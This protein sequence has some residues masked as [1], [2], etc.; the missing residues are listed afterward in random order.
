MQL[1]S[2]FRTS[3]HA[4]AGDVA[5]TVGAR[6]DELGRR[7]LVRFDYRPI[8][9][10]G[11]KPPM[12]K[13][14]SAMPTWDQA[15]IERAQELGWDDFWAE[16]P[17]G[18]ARIVPLEGAATWDDAVRAAR[19]LALTTRPQFAPGDKQ[20]QAVLQLADG[21]FHA[22]GLGGI[23]EARLGMWILRMG[24]YPGYWSPPTATALEPEVVAIVG[25][26]PTTYDTRGRVGVPVP[27]M[28]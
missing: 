11:A 22:A 7:P 8:A 13:V 17:A 1:R 18:A 9:A 2:A 25:A 15:T 10:P 24:S 20:A 3:R 26:S 21:S 14:A 6:L 5:S 23:D 12:Q 27:P 19:T 28:R 4:D 16:H